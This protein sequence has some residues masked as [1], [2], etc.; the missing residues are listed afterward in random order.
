MG[1]LAKLLSIEQPAE[2]SVKSLKLPTRMLSFTT[3][4]SI[5]LKPCS[6]VRSVIRAHLEVKV[7]S[8]GSQSIFITPHRNL[9]ITRVL[10]MANSSKTDAEWRAILSPEQ[11]RACLY[12]I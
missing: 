9:Y 8:T 6:P 5:V 3:I 4:S 7:G 11:V 12:R 2:S 10:A 1:M